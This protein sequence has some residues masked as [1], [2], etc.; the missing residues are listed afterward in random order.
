MRVS[1]EYYN[2]TRC[3]FYIK[4]KKTKTSFH[5]IQSLCSQIRIAG[6]ALVLFV[7]CYVCQTNSKVNTG[8]VQTKYIIVCG[9]VT[10]TLNPLVS[11]P[12]ANVAS[13]LYCYLVAQQL[14]MSSFFCGCF[15]FVFVPLA[16][17]EL[18]SQH[19]DS[20]TRPN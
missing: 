8:A 5:K 14:Y 17:Y 10:S 13:F 4:Q 1:Y 19:T 6:F 16:T 2:A 3:R 15:L 12:G 18:T 7:S 9:C 11:S 20:Q